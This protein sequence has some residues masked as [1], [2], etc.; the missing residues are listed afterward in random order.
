MKS[1]LLVLVFA[2]LLLCPAAFA[3]EPALAT[4]TQP[5]A[6]AGPVDLTFLHINDPHGHTAPYKT[7]DGK[8]VGGYARLATLVEGARQTSRAAR[9]FLVHAG[10]EF[11]RGD[12][13]TESTK[14][15]ANIAIMNQLGFDAWTL[16]NGDF[17]GGWPV[18]KARIGEFKGATLAANVVVRDTNEQVGKPYV[19][20]QAGPVKV[21]FLGLCFLSPMDNSFWT[22]RVSDAQETAEKLV[23]EL[24]KQADVIV[25]VT[26]HGSWLDKRIGS[27]VEGIDLVIGAHT[28]QVLEKGEHAKSPSG[29][30]VL[31]VQAG[32]Y[33]QYLGRVDMRVVRTD[34][35]WRV[36]QS[37]AMLV[38]ID[39]KIK[40]DPAMAAF[41][42][43]LSQ[44]GGKVLLQTPQ[45][46]KPAAEK[47]AAAVPV[48]K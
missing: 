12:A 23:P 18:L 43:K 31:V 47:P 16:G 13:L 46:E 19:I 40:P 29:R 37:S 42:A 25:G 9:V 14:G 33:M 10:D 28:H 32:E 26:H 5:A 2:L 45:P 11:S 8:D 1:R 27:A 7:E 39:D 48:A 35:V 36:S 22:F 20:L 4:E 41:I 6:A 17:Y 38:P 3:A 34:G 21:A 24:R 30:D 15:A 44:P